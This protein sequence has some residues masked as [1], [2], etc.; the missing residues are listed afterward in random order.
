MIRKLILLLLVA[1]SFSV[2]AKRKKSRY[3]ISV[4]ARDPFM[5]GETKE[6][7]E[8]AFALMLQ[9]AFVIKGVFKTGQGEQAIINNALHKVGDVVKINLGVSVLDAKILELDIESITVTILVNGK[10]YKIGKYIK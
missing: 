10:K 7:K 4:N 3:T 2:Q 6:S 5:R 8:A 9:K 1:C